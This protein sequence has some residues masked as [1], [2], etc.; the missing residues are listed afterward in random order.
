MHCDP[1]TRLETQDSVIEQ[2]CP[3]LTTCFAFS[4]TPR[5]FASVCRIVSS[6]ANDAIFFSSNRATISG[7]NPAN[8]SLCGGN[9]RTQG[10]QNWEKGTC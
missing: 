1:K 4:M 2:I 5:T 7:S 6:A 3:T 9:K 8:T 10:A